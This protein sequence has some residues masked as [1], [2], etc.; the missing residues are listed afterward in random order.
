MC[1][2]HAKIKGNLLTY[3]LTVCTMVPSFNR[4]S[5]VQR[6][7][8]W[9]RGQ[10]ISVDSG[11][12][13]AANAPQ[14]GAQLQ[15]RAVPCRQTR[16]EAGHTLVYLLER[17]HISE[18]LECP[19]SFVRLSV[20][21]KSVFYQ[22]GWTDRAV[23]VWMLPSTSAIHCIIKKFGYFKKERHS[24]FELY[25]KIQAFVTASRSCCQKES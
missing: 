24:P 5:G 11:G 9:A 19:R 18:D 8:C 20:R 13:P 10:G 1:A 23:S 25:P 2:W 4:S 12:R 17:R 22:N 6:V 15:M 7:C 14:H 3:W 21:H 16:D